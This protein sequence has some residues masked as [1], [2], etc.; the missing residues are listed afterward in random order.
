MKRYLLIF[1]ILCLSPGLLN[2]QT[3]WS[4]RQCIDYAVENNL[5]IRQQ[6]LVVENSELKLNSSRNSRLPNLSG[7][8]SQSF[9]FGRSPSM[10]TGIYEAHTSA[11]VGVSLNSSVPIFAGLRATS[12][13]QSSQFNLLAA[14]EGL[15]K[16]EENLSLTV[17]SYYLDVLFKKELLKV[18]NRQLELTTRQVE[19]TVALVDAGSVPRSNLLDINAE[20]AQNQS[21]VVVAANDLS[22]ALLDLALLLNAPSPETFDVEEPSIDNAVMDAYTETLSPE[23]IYQTAIETKPHIKEAEYMVEA[24]KR[25]LRTA[26]SYLWPSINL[27]MSYNN[28][29]DHI[30]KDN[31][32]N[33]SL[34]NQ[35]QNNRRAAIGISMNVPIF[36]RFQTRN[37]I[38]SAKLGVASRNIELESAKLALHKEIYQ[39]Y[40]KA[41]SSRSR[42]FSKADAYAAAAE[43]YKYTEERYQNGRSSVYELMDSQTKMIVSLS[44]QL[45]AKY[46][47]LFRLKILRF[48]NGE[49]IDNL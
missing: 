41:S 27:G 8:A 15:K 48:Y 18:T 28:G 1:A 35:L 38:R 16:A 9:N 24:G 31:F 20:K 32:N 45:Q 13:V 22:Q 17:T 47:F 49:T 19:R 6:K 14:T 37:Q 34:S 7:G 46:D 33:T 44:E 40:N 42:Y 25:D 3:K 23:D 21:N 10:A 11:G 5:D 36:N 4:L 29:F 43:A 39:A 2:A 12:E 26:R 30:F